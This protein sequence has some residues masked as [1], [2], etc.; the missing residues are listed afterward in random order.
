MKVLNRALAG[1][2][3]LSM[4]IFF[5]SCGSTGTSGSDAE[6]DQSVDDEVAEETTAETEEDVQEEEETD[7]FDESSSAEES[8]GGENETAVEEAEPEEELPVL[9]TDVTVTIPDT[10]EFYL[11]YTDITEDVLPPTPASFYT[12]YEA[13]DGCVYVDIC[14]AYKNLETTGADA[15]EIL[16]GT[17][18][19]SG[20]YEYS[21]SSTIEE[22][23]RGNFTYTNITSIDPLATEYLHYL[24]EVPEELA[25]SDASVIVE[26]SISG[27]EYQIIVREGTTGPVV[28]TSAGDADGIEISDNEVVETESSIF[29]VEYS[30]ITE[31]VIPPVPA[32]FYTHYEADDGKVYVDVCVAYENIEGKSIMADDAISAS[33]TY[34]EKYEY[35]GFSIIEKD[36]RSSFTYTNITSVKPLIVSY[37]HYLFEVPEEL[38][39]G[40]ES[41]EVTLKIDG[42]SYIYTI[43]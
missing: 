20:M 41:I 11:E 37:I 34:A 16:S 19:Y 14:I 33:L 36:S 29:Y 12:H 6:T 25:T 24:F 8:A 22:N 28:T 17:L 3:I 38:A 10:A 9:E 7:A 40:T 2:L 35:N 15:D 31:D 5:A 13:D 26:L 4:T 21:G 1:M 43:R 42:G 30:D 23:N 27:E 18:I 32:S 39:E